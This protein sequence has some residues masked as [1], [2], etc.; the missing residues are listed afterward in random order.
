M[1][2][3][4]KFIFCYW[5]SNDTSYIRITCCMSQRLH[6]EVEALFK[7]PPPPDPRVQGTVE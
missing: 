5:G 4:F 2:F 1:I 6:S 3:F 7:P